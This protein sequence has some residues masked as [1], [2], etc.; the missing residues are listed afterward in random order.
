VILAA[1]VPYLSTI[2]DYFMQDDFGVVQ[3]LTS[4]PW[5][6]FPRWFTM[7]WMEQI[8]GFTPDEIRPFV[9]FTYQLTGKWAPHRP[10]LH[11]VVNIAFHAA[12]AV[13]VM[14]IARR[15]AGLAPAAAAFAGV[16][17][18]VLPSQIET[19]AWITGRVDGMPTFF[20]LATF[21]TYV[22]WRERTGT[23]FYVWS[24]V[25]FFIALFSKQNAITVP[26]T[27]AVYDLLLLDRERRGTL[28]A[29]VKA[30]APFVAMTSGYLILRRVVLG[31]S[32]RGGV[33]S[34]HAVETFVTV[35]ERHVY[36]VTTGHLPPLL[37]WE[38]AAGV[39]ILVLWAV[40]VAVRPSLT[41]L[42][43]FCA[44]WWVIGTAPLL[45]VG[46]ESPRHVY[47]AS[48]AWAFLVALPYTAVAQRFTAR[49]VATALTAATVALTGVYLVRLH[50]DL[51]EWHV[52]AD[53][54]KTAVERLRDE[55]VAAP[56]GTL[57]LVSVPRRSWEWGIPFV[58]QPPYQPQ[59]LTARVRLVGPWRLHCCGP[60]H[61]GR[62]ATRQL[63]E[64]QNSPERP[65]IIALYFSPRTGAVARAT[66]AENIELRE[67]I[68]VLL[69]TDTPEALDGALSA[70]LERMA[71]RAAIS[72]LRHRD[73]PRCAG[74]S[75][76]AA[77]PS[78]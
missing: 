62:Y 54:S 59:D 8:W 13:L 21:L 77:P 28:W 12:N 53:V 55:I 2:P 48:A 20:Y 64:W 76:A 16:I 40:A 34:W 78:C 24:L 39:A 23:R 72:S 1:V 44:A 66:D 18:A 73:A 43:A 51:Q 29:C 5:T 52:L 17:F 46:Y 63:R 30:W 45:V 4:R 11:H 25:L 33:Q 60:D 19:A 71:A 6:T 26:A 70:L 68:P 42:V 69:Q 50:R 36:R 67:L 61:W 37:D 38:V 65:P 47:L 31:Q 75:A 74:P 58:L 35:V 22:I 49:W 41:R 9:A 15:A 57:F 3:L 27:L 10:E 14:A 7:P 56:Q 32:V